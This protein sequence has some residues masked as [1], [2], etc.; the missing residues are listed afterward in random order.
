MNILLCSY[1]FAPSVGGIETVSRILAKEF[2]E[3]GHSVRIVTETT[4]SA[5]FHLPVFRAPS[6]RMMNDL[7]RW[8]DLIFHNNISL[9]FCLAQSLARK[10]WV[11]AHHTWIARADGTR[12]LAEWLKR[13]VLRFA[14]NI[15]ISSEIA[16]ALPVPS[17]VIPDPYDAEAFHV[18]SRANR[19]RDLLFAG[20]L[21]SD[22]GVDLLL[23]A[24]AM[25]GAEGYRPKLTIVGDG[26]ERESLESQAMELPLQGQVSF[27]GMKTS[28]ELAALMNSHK[29]VVVPSRWEEPFGVVALEGIACGCGIIA[30]RGGGLPEAVGP[31]GRLVENG[32]A[33]AIAS[34]VRELLN[35]SQ[36]IDSSRSKAEA[37]LKQH[38]PSAIAERYLA[39][40][41][42]AC[43]GQL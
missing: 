32:S 31:C 29:I 34:A 35:D 41:R 11:V 38:Y 15:S 9:R 27:V 18:D 36:R 10:P 37:H 21:V 30:T 1:L 13:R 7:A 28:A 5:A 22:K 43:E 2:A 33:A 25:L 8:A 39:V 23:E 16:R 24:L 6:M 42:S 3:A 19:S 26:P 4:G 14:T 20:R 12:G 17:I 40:F